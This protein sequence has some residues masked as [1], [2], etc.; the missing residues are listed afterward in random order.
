MI[1][2]HLKSHGIKGR[3]TVLDPGPGI[4]GFSEIFSE[5]Y[6][7]HINYVPH[8]GIKSIDPFNKKLVTEQGDFSFDDAILMPPQQAGDL[9]WDAGLIAKDITGKLTGWAD[10]H[11]IHLHAREDNRIFL[12]GDLIDKASPLFGHY[13]KTGHMASHLGRIAASGIAAQAKGTY[14]E[15]ILPESI[16][17]VFTRVEPMEALHIETQYRFRGDGIIVQKA[18]QKRDSH[19]GDADTMWAKEKFAELLPTRSGQ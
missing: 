17:H 1:G 10:Q 9:I 16:C 18:Q 14:P 4:L 8:A 6:R 3:L 2:W 13:P 15:K 5:Q 11:P 12:I 19:P 7:D